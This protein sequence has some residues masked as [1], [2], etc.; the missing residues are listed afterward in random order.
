MSRIDR[1]YA[2]LVI[3]KFLSQWTVEASEIPSDHQMI[4]V[5]Y[6]PERAPFIGKGRWSWPL[7]LLHDKP[8]NETIHELGIELH[9]RLQHLAPGDRSS[10]PQTL[11]QE[12]KDRIKE[13][14]TAAAKLQM[15]KI[16]KCIAALQ[17]DLKE[18]RKAPTLDDDEPA[19]INVI[20]LEREIDHLTKKRYK[21]AYNRAQAQW[22][23][24]GEQ[25]SKYWSK[26]NSPRTPRDLMYRLVH[27]ETQRMITRSDEMA[28]LTRDYRDNIQKEGLLDPLQ[29]P[30]N[31]TLT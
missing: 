9:N 25:I 15:C 24:K 29:S 1:I 5:R 17:N 13:E 14:A 2:N 6:A 22:F 23:M 12:F 31:R 3:R 21:S 4:S 26:V 28:E 20:A 8:L 30:A 18:A 11:W 27:P 7:G 10:N 16:S 19:R